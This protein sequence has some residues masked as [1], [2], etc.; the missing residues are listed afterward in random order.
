MT[1]NN[2]INKDINL[3]KNEITRKHITEK[4]FY[5]RSHNC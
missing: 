3:L 4:H 5:F 1:T 2:E